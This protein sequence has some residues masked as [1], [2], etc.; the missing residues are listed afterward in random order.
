[1]I[2]KSVLANIP[3]TSHGY[4]FFCGESKGYSLLATLKFIINIVGYKKKE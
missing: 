1:M 4:F 2:A 3:I